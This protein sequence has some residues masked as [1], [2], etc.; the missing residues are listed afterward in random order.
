MVPF[1]NAAA[2][3]TW[4][5]YFDTID[6]VMSSPATLRW[7]ERSYAGPAE[8]RKA[9]RDILSKQLQRAGAMGTGA[10]MALY[11]VGGEPLSLPP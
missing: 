2:R 5:A 3:S 6:R 9:I 11:E 8:N 4:Q 10:G 7:L 1:A